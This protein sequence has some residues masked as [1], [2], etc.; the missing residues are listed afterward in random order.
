MNEMLNNDKAQAS[1]LFNKEE[2]I[3]STL[4]KSD[5]DISEQI[6]DGVSLKKTSNKKTIIIFSLLGACLAALVI[7]LS[8]LLIFKPNEGTP[9]PVFDVWEG[10]DTF[11]NA[12]HLVYPLVDEETVTKMDIYKDGE[13]FSFVKYWDENLGKYDWRVEGLKQLT[14]MPQ[15]LKCF[16]CGFAQ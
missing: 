12:A 4:F 7:I 3:K 10:E 8:L 11:G 5:A 1:T 13:T 14:L 2:T 6:T 16:V 9:P 15:H